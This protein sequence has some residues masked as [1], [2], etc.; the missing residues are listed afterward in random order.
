VLP[1]PA[2]L[3][4]V[5]EPPVP[6][7][8]VVVPLGEELQ[9]PAIAAAPVATPA[10]RSKAWRGRS[11]KAGPFFGG[12]SRRPYAESSPDTRGPDVAKRRMDAR[13]RWS[14]ASAARPPW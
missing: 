8:A 13:A 9:P 4:P 11:M 14:L 1:A 7:V 5:P 12:S 2:P 6:A 3:A 10:T